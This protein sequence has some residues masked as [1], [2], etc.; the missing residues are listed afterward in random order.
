MH[1]FAP[2]RVG[3][4]GT[5]NIA[6]THATAWQRTTR[7]EI[8][9]VADIERDKAA[10]FARDYAPG[11]SVAESLDALLDQTAVDLIDVCTREPAHAAVALPALQTGRHV[12]TEKIMAHTLADGAAMAEA[13]AQRPEQF[14]GVQY[15]YRWF[16]QMRLLFELAQQQTHGALRMIHVNCASQCLNHLLDSLLLLGGEPARISAMGQTRAAENQLGVDAAI[17]YLPG[18]VFAGQITF[19]NGMLATFNATTAPQKL[20]KRLPFQIT[21]VFDDGVLEVSSLSWPNQLV[22]TYRWLPDGQNLLPAADYPDPGNQPLSF[23]P[24]LEAVAQRVQ[25]E[26]PS[27]SPATWADGWRVMLVSHALVR[28]SQTHQAVE[29]SALRQTVGGPR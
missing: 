28:A 7:A 16:P 19:D 5:G 13:A 6:R 8:V 10:A 22:G 27:P 1:P 17:A 29:F 2:V 25:G 20:L 9:G 18:P 26:A 15:N 23:D 12:L 11:A 21:A 4:V 14:A 24:A 3:I